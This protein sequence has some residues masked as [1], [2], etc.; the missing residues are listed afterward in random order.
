MQKNIMAFDTGI[1]EWQVPMYGLVRRHIQGECILPT[2]SLVVQRK[3]QD[4]E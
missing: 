2:M 4:H 1:N 3:I